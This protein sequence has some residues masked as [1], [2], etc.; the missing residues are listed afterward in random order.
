[1]HYF[2]LKILCKNWASC[3]LLTVMSF[4]IEMFFV[5]HFTL[6]HLWKLLLS[7]CIPLYIYLLMTLF[8]LVVDILFYC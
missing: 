2:C 7:I 1:M 6:V 5:D 4:M 3:N 8:H